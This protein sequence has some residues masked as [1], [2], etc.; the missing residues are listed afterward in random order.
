MATR[1]EQT[2]FKKYVRVAQKLGVGVLALHY[3]FIF[4]QSIGIVFWSLLFQKRIGYL[5]ISNEPF[6][7]AWRVV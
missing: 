4:A 5:E 3:P 1:T 2:I 6:C 7:G